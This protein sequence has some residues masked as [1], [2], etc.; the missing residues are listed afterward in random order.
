MRIRSLN[1]FPF[2]I[3]LRDE[4]KA[5]FSLAD[6]LRYYW[7]VKTWNVTCNSI[8]FSVEITLDNCT[9]SVDLNG[10]LQSTIQSLRG[11]NSLALTEGDLLNVETG[12]KPPFFALYEKPG[13]PPAPTTLVGTLG[14]MIT[15]TNNPTGQPPNH[16]PSHKYGV[17]SLYLT[18]LLGVSSGFKVAD[19]IVQ[20]PDGSYALRAF[21]G[22]V[23]FDF[24]ADGTVADEFHIALQQPTNG[25]GMIPVRTT[26]EGQDSIQG[27]TGVNVVLM[28]GNAKLLS[29]PPTVVIDFAPASY[30]PYADTS[31]VPLYD[32]DTGESQIGDP[33]SAPWP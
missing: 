25:P 13:Y 19:G 28:G 22:I 27:T 9:Y 2:P 18:S 10:A 26:V 21:G 23:D 20:A 7:R 3:P 6:A 24:T 15:L 4:P 5:G 11:D 30:W 12:T 32:P 8:A 33:V 1:S 29:D 16:V 14:S 17:F 31:G